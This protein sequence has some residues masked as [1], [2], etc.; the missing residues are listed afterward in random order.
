M[1]CLTLLLHGGSFRMPHATSKCVRWNL[2][3]TFL[4]IGNAWPLLH[5]WTLLELLNPIGPSLLQTRAHW[6]SSGERL[7][8]ISGVSCLVKKREKTICALYYFLRSEKPLHSREVIRGLCINW[9]GDNWLKHISISCRP[10]RALR[11]TSLVT[12]TCH[13]KWVSQGYWVSC[14]VKWGFSL[15]RKGIVAHSILSD[16]KGWNKSKPK[17]TTLIIFGR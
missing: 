13:R 6:E 17:T 2:S 9:Q 15:P 5:S 1:L 4:E 7:E 12:A 11:L 16:R 8:F 3:K 14:R 10:Y